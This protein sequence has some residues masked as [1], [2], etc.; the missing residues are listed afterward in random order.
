MKFNT[1]LPHAE[2]LSTPEQARSLAAYIRRLPATFENRIALDTETTGLHIMRD[3]PVYFSV[4]DG[5]SRWC[6]PSEFLLDGIFDDLLADPSRWWVF[7]NAK[8]DMHMFYNYGQ[9]IRGKCLDIIVMCWLWDENRK[10]I[11]ALGLKEQTRDYMQFN[12]VSFEETFSVKGRDVATALLSAPEHLVSHYASGDAYWTWQLSEFHFQ[13]LS[14]LSFFKSYTAWEYYLD[15]ELPFTT[16]LWRM[17]RRGFYLDIP[18]LEAMRPKLEQQIDE[19]QREINRW[20]GRPI[21]VS[22][23]KQLQQLLYTDLKLKPIKWTKGGTTGNQ[24][25]STDEETL[26]MY[27][28]KGI[29][30]VTSILR[31]REA[32]KLLSTYVN[33]LLSAAVDSRVHCTNMQTGTDTGRLAVRDPNLQNIPAKSEDG[34]LIR[35]AFRATPGNKLLV[36]DYSQVEMRLMAHFANDQRMIR[37]INTGQD[38]HCYT[39]SEMMGKPYAHAVAAK[40]V[41]GNHEIELEN[42]ARKLMKSDDSISSDEAI[43]CI[44]MMVDNPDYCKELLDL[45]RA[46]K[47]VGFGLIYG[48]GPGKLSNELGVTVADAKDKM[49]KYFKVFSNVKKF[50]DGQKLKAKTREDHAVQTI[51][52][53]FRRLDQINSSNRAWASAEERRSVNAPIQGSAA[54]VCKLAMVNID[55]HPE[56]GGDSLDGGAYG[57]KQLLQVHDELIQEGPDNPDILRYVNDLTTKLMEDPGVS[58]SVSLAVEGGVADTWLEAK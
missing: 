5:K 17:E 3:I 21:N 8:F 20:A 45:R 14:K 39:V 34:K 31:F 53:R 13:N 40:I 47:A 48:I 55:Q 16:T 28:A 33:G 43:S 12:M 1:D 10:A 18:Y 24:Q 44:K 50:I 6:L 38:L 42:A 30:Q 22:S 29:P 56:L 51:L 4:S 11:G 9:L 25:P 49:D 36:K 15:V 7:A 23:P 57:F 58:L 41:D 32:Q 26:N 19:A 54:D 2:Y 46:A 35:G 37:A 27:A 52:G